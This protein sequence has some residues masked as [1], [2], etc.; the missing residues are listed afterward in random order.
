MVGL[1]AEVSWKV[2]EL[3]SRTKHSVLKIAIVKPA[4]LMIRVNNLKWP[5]HLIQSSLLH[6]L[7]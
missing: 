5:A 4:T 6:Q 1:M 2:L 7:S 3:R